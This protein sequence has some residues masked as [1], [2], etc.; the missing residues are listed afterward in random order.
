MKCNP[1]SAWSAYSWSKMDNRQRHEVVKL[2]EQE[3]GSDFAHA[4]HF[5]NRYSKPAVG[6]GKLLSK[7]KDLTKDA[8]DFYLES[9]LNT[10]VGIRSLIPTDIHLPVVRKSKPSNDTKFG[11]YLV[12]PN[13]KSMVESIHFSE[14]DALAQ[15]K[16][17]NKCLSFSSLG[18]KREVRELSKTEASST[19]DVLEWDYVKG[20]YVPHREFPIHLTKKSAIDRAS[21]DTRCIAAWSI[22]WKTW[23]AAKC[24]APEEYDYFEKENVLH[25][26]KKA[27][28][29]GHANPLRSDCWNLSETPY[30]KK[31]TSS[32]VD[33]KFLDFC[34]KL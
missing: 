26:D 2:L 25:F 7:K 8:L 14:E 9:L 21:H 10:I 19:Y 31:L 29:K 20:K 4:A 32:A 30:W 33:E 22:Q 5:G 18:A 27:L 12:V 15:M 1:K 13:G 34:S 24:K 28:L 16:R 6:A 17:M 23:K 11:V 3:Y